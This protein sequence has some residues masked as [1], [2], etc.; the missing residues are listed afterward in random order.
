MRISTLILANNGT[1]TN[2]KKATTEEVKHS[3]KVDN[4]NDYFQKSNSNPKNVKFGAQKMSFLRLVLRA[5]S[6]G[7][8]VHPKDDYASLLEKVSAEEQRV[9]NRV[10]APREISDAERAWEGYQTSGGWFP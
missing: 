7:V 3:S 9:I 5:E 2:Y 8:N 1:K 10:E 6:L 4:S